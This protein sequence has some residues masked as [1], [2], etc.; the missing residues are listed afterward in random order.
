[1]CK[2]PDFAVHHNSDL[3]TDFGVYG[4]AGYQ[5]WPNPVARD[6]LFNSFHNRIHQSTPSE[7]LLQRRLPKVHKHSHEHD[8]FNRH[9]AL[10]HRT[11][12]YLGLRSQ[13]PE[14]HQTH[15]DLQSLQIISILRGTQA[16]GR[17]HRPQH[18]RVVST[19]VLHDDGDCH[20]SFS[21]L[22]YWKRYLRWITNRLRWQWDSVWWY[23]G[24]DL[25]GVS[26][27]DDLW[28]W[29][30]DSRWLL[31]EVH[32]DRDHGV[33]RANFGFA[34]RYNQ[35]ELWKGILRLWSHEKTIKNDLRVGEVCK[36]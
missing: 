11:A 7:Q 4:I 33:R 21:G 29:R 23:P 27:N 36:F 13:L 14:D 9:H 25:V 26:D 15:Q 10:L 32:W 17:S 16:N 3:C 19:Y 1:M 34:C 2:Q 28:I 18:R 6:V 12:R 5:Q 35:R 30:S 22:H 31:R 24:R 20:F 8:R